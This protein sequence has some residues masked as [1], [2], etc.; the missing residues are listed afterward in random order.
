MSPNVIL[1]YALLF[2][3]TNGHFRDSDSLMGTIISKEF[4]QQY[5]NAIYVKNVMYSLS[6][7][8]NESISIKN[9]R[10]YFQCSKCRELTHI[11]KSSLKYT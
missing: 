6:L 7:S 10:F 8:S 1:Q 5:Q 3:G 11:N 4:L 2:S 9:L